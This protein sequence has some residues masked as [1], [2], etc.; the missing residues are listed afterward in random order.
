MSD[1]TPDESL[2]LPSLV[3]RNFRGID[4]LTIPRLVLQ[5]RFVGRTHVA[6]RAR[7]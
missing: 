6:D 4:E 3:I 5:P 7:S 1:Q 2:H